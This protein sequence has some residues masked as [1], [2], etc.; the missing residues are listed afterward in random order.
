MQNQDTRFLGRTPSRM[1]S[2][3][4]HVTHALFLPSPQSAG[5]GGGE[6]S[7]KAQENVASK[8]AAEVLQEKTWKLWLLSVRY[9]TLVPKAKSPRSLYPFPECKIPPLSSSWL[10]GGTEVTAYQTALLYSFPRTPM[11]IP[12]CPYLVKA[13][14]AFTY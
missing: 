6:C 14:L 7:A 11:P 10:K 1:C 12:Y 8:M 4:S 3:V 13:S 5:G 2:P 9:K